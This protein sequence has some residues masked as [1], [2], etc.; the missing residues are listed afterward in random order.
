MRSLCTLI[1]RIY[2]SG[3]SCQSIKISTTHTQWDPGSRSQENI[4]R[5]VKG[6]KKIGDSLGHVQ[7][8]G[9][10]LT[11][12]SCGENEEMTVR[13]SQHV[14]WHTCSGE[15]LNVELKN[16]FVFFYFRIN[17]CCSP[18]R[19]KGGIA[20]LCSD[21]DNTCILNFQVDFILL[22]TRNESDMM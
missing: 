13:V 9:G 11:Y 14:G 3:P 20:A 12:W 18:K 22:T 2:G 4:K 21:R 1:S 10:P 17:F 8:G 6:S 16:R 5:T 7:I 15:K 19:G